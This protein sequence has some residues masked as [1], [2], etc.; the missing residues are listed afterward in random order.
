LGKK[1]KVGIFWGVIVTPSARD[2][3]NVLLQ[4]TVKKEKFFFLSI[5]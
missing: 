3:K 4:T 2:A 5:N 1:T